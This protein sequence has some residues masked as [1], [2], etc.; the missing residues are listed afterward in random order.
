MTIALWCLVA[1]AVLHTISKGPLAMHM[2]KAPGGYDNN[3]PREQAASLEGAGK[4]ALAIHLNQIESFPLFAAGVLVA[5]A[6][7][8]ASSAVDYCAIAYIAARIVYIPV[9]LKDLATLRTMVWSVGYG[10]SIAL[11]C[12]P[13]WA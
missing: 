2:A 7:G 11:I 3:K 10:A 5:T 1:A 6:A 9:Y 13:A 8:V 12:S 4:R